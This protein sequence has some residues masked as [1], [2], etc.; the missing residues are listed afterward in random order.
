MF[1]QWICRDMHWP[2]GDYSN[3]LLSNL[4]PY[5]HLRCFYRACTVHF[6]RNVYDLRKIVSHEVLTAM[7]SLATSEVIPD[8]E[9]VFTLICTG[10]KKA[11]GR[12]L[13]L[14]STNFL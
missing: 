11:N 6:K 4:D 1:C 7:L 5:E 12:F 10:G 14:A 9:A 2:C 3:V 13:V 8:L